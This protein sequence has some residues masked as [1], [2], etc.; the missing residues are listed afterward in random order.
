MRDT[1]PPS[2]STPRWRSPTR[3]TSAQIPDPRVSKSLTRTGPD[4]LAPAAL[5]K[6]PWARAIGRDRFGLW[7]ELLYQGPHDK[8]APPVPYRMRWIPPGCFVMGS[9]DDEPGRFRDEGP[10]HLVVITRG[11]WLGETPV[12]QALWQAVTGG[13]PSGPRRT[14]GAPEVAAARARR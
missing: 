14:S 6:P 10:Q 11:Y 3:T 13:N 4:H 12:T 9:P 1:A 7:A 8:R 5:T 2:T